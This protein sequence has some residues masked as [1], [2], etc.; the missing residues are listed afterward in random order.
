MTDDA[1]G[2]GRYV[3]LAA[4]DEGVWV[5]D[6]SDPAQPHLI[7]LANTPGRARG[8]A[9]V[10]DLAYVGDGDGGLLVLHVVEDL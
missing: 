10:G 1:D 4:G 9:V 7:G 3:F 8:L 2:S 5:A 6:A